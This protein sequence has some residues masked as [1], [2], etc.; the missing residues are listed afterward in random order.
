MAHDLFL[1]KIEAA[2]NKL[3]TCLTRLSN[4]AESTNQ[5]VDRSKVNIL[6]SFLL[7]FR[8]T[9]KISRETRCVCVFYGQQ[10]NIANTA[11]VTYSTMV[12]Y[13]QG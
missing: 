2:L 7:T 6:V 10:E 1:L 11:N 9:L 12:V 3:G 8:F 5:E 13:G 4:E